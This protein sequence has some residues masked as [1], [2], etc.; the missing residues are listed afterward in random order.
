MSGRLAIFP[1]SFDPLTSGH[2][3]IVRRGLRLFDRVEIAL[4]INPGKT[5]MFSVDERRALILEEFADAPG[6]SIGSLSGLLVD[7]ATDVGAVAI[8]RGL[9]G[10]SDFEYELK[11]TQMNRTLAPH[12]ETVF[13]AAETER[14]FVSSSLIKEVARLG[15]DVSQ[16]LPAHV[17]VA[18]LAKLNT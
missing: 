4:A 10:P 8:L 5:P 3:S 7:Y 11:M 17:H 13:L 16:H 12:V 15:G 6:V 1:G 14:S 2:A 18:L 9:R